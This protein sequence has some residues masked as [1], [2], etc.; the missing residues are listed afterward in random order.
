MI[1]TEPSRV[2][3][4]EVYKGNYTLSDFKKAISLT[5]HQLEDLQARVEEKLSDVAS[6]IFT[7]HLLLLKDKE[8]VGSMTRKIEEGVSPPDAIILIARHYIE[9]FSRG[10]NAYIKE[11]VQDIE[12]LSIRLLG[13]LVAEF[14]EL[15]QCENHIIVAQRTL[16]F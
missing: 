5:V 7:A 1:E 10:T 9:I 6:L 15:C 14:R 13:N 11:K 2:F 16:S 3:S 8:F 4:I 12:D